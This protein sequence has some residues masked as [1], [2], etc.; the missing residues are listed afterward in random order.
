MNGERTHEVSPTVECF[1]VDTFRPQS[2]DIYNGLYFNYLF[3]RR[4]HS[5]SCA[6]A[7]DRA[8]IDVDLCSSGAGCPPESY[9]LL[10]NST[11]K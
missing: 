10:E 11:L 7:I 4:D 3:L 2:L 1:C 6:I 9:I 8:D 5:S